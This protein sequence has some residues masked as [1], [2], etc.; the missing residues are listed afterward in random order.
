MQDEAQGTSGTYGTPEIPGRAGEALGKRDTRANELI[1]Q[2]IEFML[3]Y[4]T[5]LMSLHNFFSTTQLRGHRLTEDTL[6]VPPGRWLGTS[7]SDR[8]GA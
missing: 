2:S 6:H 3:A 7:M 1:E 4:R 5:S 8:D